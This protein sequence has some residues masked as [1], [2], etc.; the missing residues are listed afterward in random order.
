MK[1]DRDLVRIFLFLLATGLLASPSH[2][3]QV[4]DTV[5]VTVETEMRATPSFEDSSL[6]KLSKG[7]KAKVVESEDPFLK[8][9]T[10][11]SEGWVLKDFLI[12]PEKRRRFRKKLTESGNGSPEYSADTSPSSTNRWLFLL[13]FLW[14]VG[15]AALIGY[16]AKE[17]GR[18]PAVWAV[19][20]IVFSPLLAA[21]VLIAAGDPE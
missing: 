11:A 5:V 10:D 19:L 7:L 14:W 8:I 16:A 18:E 4:G 17:R 2:S 6:Q 20:S 21:L 3:Q 1:G 9:K 15:I 12:N 13:A